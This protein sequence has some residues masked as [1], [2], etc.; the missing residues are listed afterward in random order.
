[1]KKS[2]FTL[3]VITLGLI[4]LVIIFFFAHMLMA[5]QQIDVADIKEIDITV[6]DIYY[7]RVSREN[8]LFVVSDS[9]KYL[10]KGRSTLEEYSVSELYESITEGTKLSLMYRE[11]HTIFGNVN[12]VVDARS[13]TETYRSLK[14]F[15]LG[16]QGLPAFLTIMFS[17]IELVYVGIVL[18]YIWV[19]YTEFKWV[20][21]K[22][23]NH[24]FNPKIKS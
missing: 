15:N 21:K 22:F 12:L 16:K 9:T 5:S 1:M 20:F 7:S 2:K 14:E 23:K 11:T 13:E 19:N 8:W 24:L 10:F 18:M 6:D 3:M 4:Q 17:L